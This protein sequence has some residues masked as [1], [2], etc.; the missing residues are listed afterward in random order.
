M[1]EKLVLTRKNGSVA[2]VTINRPKIMNAV[3]IETLTLLLSAF[4]R[5]A[6]DKEVRVVTLEGAGENFCVGADMALLNEKFDSIQWYDLLKNVVGKLILTMRTMPQPVICKVRGNAYGFGVG[7]ALAGDFVVASDNARFCEIF[8][9]MGLT[10]DGGSSYFLPRLICMAKARELALLGGTI[11]GKTAAS[12]GLIYRSVPEKA[13]DKEVSSLAQM[14]AAKSSQSLKS[15]KGA[16]ERSFDMSLED[17]LEWEA[18]HQ[19]IFLQSGEHKTAV[20]QF[21]NTHKKK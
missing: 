7:L 5:L 11:D 6:I 14:L 20:Q 21:L 10:L 12:I 13:L 2:A 15:I 17:A 8:V 3:N 1:T 19:A 4:E 16:L 9:N 18:S